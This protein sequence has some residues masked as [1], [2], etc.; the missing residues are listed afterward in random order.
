MF[1]FLM[2]LIAMQWGAEVLRLQPISQLLLTS[3]LLRSWRPGADVAELDFDPGETTDIVL[4]GRKTMTTAPASENRFK[5]TPKFA[6]I[7]ST[8]GAY[9]IPSQ[10]RTRKHPPSFRKSE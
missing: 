3:N 9:L 4:Y 5:R 7:I 2:Q 10:I 8:T 6:S 1:C